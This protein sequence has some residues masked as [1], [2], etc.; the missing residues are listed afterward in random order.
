M[1]G[2]KEASRKDALKDSR[3]SE[4]EGKRKE[5]V[6][7]TFNIGRGWKSKAKRTLQQA[8]QEDIDFLGL[9]ETDNSVL[10]GTAAR[11]AGYTLFYAKRAALVIRKRWEK[12]VVSVK[13]SHD[14]RAVTVRLDVNGRTFSIT[15][16]YFPTALDSKNDGSEELELARKIARTVTRESNGTDIS[17]LLADMNETMCDTDRLGKT[18][19]KHAGE[20]RI[21]RSLEAC[22]FWDA[23]KKG[24]TDQK[25][26]TC[27]RQTKRGQVESRIDYV[28]VKVE[29][30]EV[31]RANVGVFKRVKSDHRPVLVRMCLGLDELNHETEEFRLFLPK[32]TSVSME[33]KREFAE[34]K[35]L[36]AAIA[37]MGDKEDVE[38]L[39]MTVA[40][41]MRTT[42][43]Q[44]LGGPQMRGEQTS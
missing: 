32:V 24:N 21:G 28:Y 26:F 6:V 27:K 4:S 41:T 25:G 23:Y 36:R 19:M 33:A 13:I 2:K 11:R 7:G 40:A 16:A 29:D 39:A 18:T 14:G 5:I 1:N 3:K 30:V 8:G 10:I 15:S 22:G 42:A 44:V 31:R 37:D 38:R 35:N 43:F 9:Q 20:G 17:I 34:A 12:Y